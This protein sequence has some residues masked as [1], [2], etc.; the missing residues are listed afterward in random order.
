MSNALQEHDDVVSQLR[1]LAVD[2]AP[3]V[4][5]KPDLARAVLARGRTGRANQR[6]RWRFGAVGGLLA[7]AAVAAATLPGQGDYFLH[8]QPSAAM[9]PTVFAGEQVFVNKRIAPQRRD[10]V[11]FHFTYADGEA[12]GIQ[13]V[14]GLPGDRIACPDAGSGRCE[15]LSIN[16]RLVAESYVSDSA[17]K[18]FA[19]TTVPPGHLFLLGDLRE[20]AYDSRNRGAVDQDVVKGVVVRIVDEEGQTRPVPGAPTRPGPDEDDIIDPPGPVPPAG[21]WEPPGR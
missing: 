17:G 19:E 16:G 13:R 9:E 20:N 10:L 6:R 11:V 14:L 4:C 12:D 3:T 1:A 8:Y 21:S 2:A 5:A 18:P 15:A 7:T